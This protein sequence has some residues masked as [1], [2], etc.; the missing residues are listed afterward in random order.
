METKICSYTEKNERLQLIR[1]SEEGNP[2]FIFEIRANR[3]LIRRFTREQALYARLYFYH[4]VHEV[5]INR[6][7]TMLNLT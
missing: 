1:I 7:H 4:C 3:I 2:N 5:V 6:S